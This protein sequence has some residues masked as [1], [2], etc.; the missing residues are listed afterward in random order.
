MKRKN[1]SVRKNVNTV[2]SSIF[3]QNFWVLS[4][5]SSLLG[6]MHPMDTVLQ[7]AL[8]CYPAKYQLE[9]YVNSVGT[10]ESVVDTIEGWST[11]LAT[12]FRREEIVTLNVYVIFR[13]QY[14]C[15]F[16]YIVS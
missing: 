5:M 1:E 3:L 13:L 10:Q 14:E 11:T 16:H 12:T 2:T 8:I 7:I 4:L 9:Y 15:A 6:N